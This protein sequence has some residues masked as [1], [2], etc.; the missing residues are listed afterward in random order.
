[1]YHVIGDLV[2][3][4]HQGLGRLHT[5][6]TIASAGKQSVQASEQAQPGQKTLYFCCG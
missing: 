5:T 1:M 4:F 6:H 2:D 3:M